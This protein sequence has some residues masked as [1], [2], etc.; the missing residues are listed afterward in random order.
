MSFFVNPYHP[1]LR[2][3]LVLHID[4]IAEKCAGLIIRDRL[5]IITDQQKPFT[6]TGPFAIEQSDTYILNEF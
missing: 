6:A 3:G 5:K 2:L 1:G 4:R